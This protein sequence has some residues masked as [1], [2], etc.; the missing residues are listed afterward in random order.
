MQLK[1]ILESVIKP[2]LN[3]IYIEPPFLIDGGW[4]CGWF[5]REHALHT[6]VLARMLRKEATIKTGDFV[7]HSEDGIGITSIKTGA[8]HAWC[9]IEAVAPVD[10]SMTFAHFEGRFPHLPIV[11]GTGPAGHFAVRC[12]SSEE[13]VRNDPGAGTFAISYIERETVKSAP[14]KLVRSPYSFLY[15]PA[16]GFPKWTEIHGDEIFSQ[17][18]A[19]LYRLA[20]GNIRPLASSQSPKQIIKFI[21]SRYPNATKKILSIIQGE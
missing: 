15:A 7:I 18:T 4:D 17:T 20:R 11:Y 12:F 16:K 1:R 10:L 9:E 13:D 14:E 2:E 19:H 6:Y 21:K 5:C 8:D 3:A